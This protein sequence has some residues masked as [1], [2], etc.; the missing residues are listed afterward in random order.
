MKNV[1]QSLIYR[2]ADHVCAAHK[3]SV[4]A[5]LFWSHSV[6]LTVSIDYLLNSAY[7]IIFDFYVCVYLLLFSTLRIF[8]D[9]IYFLSLFFFI[10][11]YF[12]NVLTFGEHYYANKI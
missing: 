8:F 10:L 5:N 4:H 9:S 6:M 12:L 11:I 2:L 7:L 3:K 1:L